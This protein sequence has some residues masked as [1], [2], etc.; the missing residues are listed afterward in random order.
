MPASSLPEPLRER[1]WTPSPSLLDQIQ[2]GRAH[3]K[4]LGV[5]FEADGGADVF[6]ARPVWIAVDERDSDRFAGTITASRV[7]REGLRAG[8]RLDA[9]L[10]RI[11]DLVI[12]DAGGAPT[13]NEERARFALG[14]RVLVG[15]T[16]L[17]RTGDLIEQRQFAG[18]LVSVDSA[19]GLE[20]ELDDD[21]RRW[22]PPDVRSL[23]EAPPGE[24][25][26]R[27]TGEVEH[28]PDYLLTWT[29]T[30]EK[31]PR[32]ASGRSSP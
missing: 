11:F 17:S 31:A 26:L 29:I 4:V 32:P 10:S 23:E 12:L 5:E 22:L 21:S 6:S 16:V 2:P 9:P 27:S 28:D 24:Y 8:D 19:H 18:S 20:L 3:V 7:D 25:R 30:R 1:W 13:L 15:L 14:K